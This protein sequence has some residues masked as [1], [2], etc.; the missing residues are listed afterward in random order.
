[1]SVSQAS[2]PI[3]EFALPSGRRLENRYDAL[4]RRTR[5]SE[6]GGDAITTWQFFGPS[7]VAEF[8]LGNGLICTQL[9]NA[10]SR[11]AAVG[12]ASNLPSWGDQSSDRLGYHG[13][14]RPNTKRNLSGGTESINFRP[15]SQ[16]TSTCSH[17]SRPDPHRLTNVTVPG[18]RAAGRNGVWGVR[19][20]DQPD[21]VAGLGSGHGVLRLAGNWEFETSVVRHA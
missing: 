8:T 14:G 4:Y 18:A 7:R 9:N 21:S 12:Q 6:A 19:H 13:A 10:R 3:A 11:S 20:G 15:F 2:H 1:M 5:V 17:A 16:L